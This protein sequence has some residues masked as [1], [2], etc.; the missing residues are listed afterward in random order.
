MH[1]RE[2]RHP[3]D[4]PAIAWVQGEEQAVII[5][6]VGKMGI[7]VEGLMHLFYVDDDDNGDGLPQL[8]LDFLNHRVR[9][10]VRWSD[11]NLTGLKLASPLPHEIAERIRR[12]GGH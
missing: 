11:G 12:T 2:P 5:R 4:F 1:Y 10:G 3:T 6:E 8:T 7:K 9:C